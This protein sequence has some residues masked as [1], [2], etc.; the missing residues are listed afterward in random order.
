MGNKSRKNYSSFNRDHKI[1]SKGDITMVDV[2]IEELMLSLS[3]IEELKNYPENQSATIM[4]EREKNYC[5]R[6]L[7]EV[8]EWL[9]GK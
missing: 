3:R 7:N 6:M 4:L 5:E 9:K 2:Y 8:K 1:S